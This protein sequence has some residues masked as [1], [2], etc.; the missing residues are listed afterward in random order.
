MF[1]VKLAF[2]QIGKET[3]CLNLAGLDYF[4]CKFEALLWFFFTFG[5]ILGIGFLVVAGIKYT[6]SQ[7]KDWHNELIFIILGIILIVASFSLPVIIFSFLK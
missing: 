3:G 5:L 6:L 7:G 2:A 4:M 1:L